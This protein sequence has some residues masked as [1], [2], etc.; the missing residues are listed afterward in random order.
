MTLVFA[1]NNVHKLNEIRKLASEGYEILSLNEIGCTAELPETGLT[2]EENALQ[3]ARFVFEK[4]NANCFADD[5]GLEAAALNGEPGVYSARY[6]G[7]NK[8]AEDNML[9]LLDK[10]KDK[11]NRKAQFR[12]VIAGII[13][14]QE[15]VCEGIVRGEILKKKKGKSGF[16]YDP[17]FLPEGSTL[18][19]AEM[20]LEKKNKL[21]HRAKALEKFLEILDKTR[22]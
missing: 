21:S 18:S 5:T 4:Y 19:F 12:T 22:K 7:K 13:N 15:F 3:K 14:G 6:A 16:G 9:K 1:S 2:L 20:T 11:K 10:L 17:V 8:N